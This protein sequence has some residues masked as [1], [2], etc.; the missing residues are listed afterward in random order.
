MSSSP[1]G[2][3]VTCNAPL[4]S[5]TSSDSGISDDSS[6]QPVPWEK[7][8]QGREQQSNVPP[9]SADRS[10]PPSGSKPLTPRQSHPPSLQLS[11]PLPPQ[12]SRQPWRQTPEQSQPPTP[13]P[14]QTSTPRQSQ[15][16]T[17][18]Q[19]QSSTPRETQPPK[20][21]QSQP[22]TPRQPSMNRSPCGTPLSTPRQ[23]QMPQ[24]SSKPIQ[25]R[26]GPSRQKPAGPAVP[27][28]ALPRRPSNPVVSTGP[29]GSTCGSTGK[30][31]QE[32]S[33]GPRCSPSCRPDESAID[34]GS[35]IPKYAP[36]PP[37]EKAA[38]C[39]I[40]FND[41]YSN[42]EELGALVNQGKRVEQSLYHGGCITMML[43]YR[44]AKVRASSNLVGGHQEISWGL[45]PVT[46][47]PVDSFVRMPKFEDA[48][49]WIEFVDWNR[50]GTVDV[51]KLGAAVAAL[52]PIDEDEAEPLVRKL[53]KVGSGDIISREELLETVLPHLQ[54]EAQS[55]TGDPGVE[56]TTYPNN[57]AV[58][59]GGP[60]H[61][62]RDSMKLL[63]KNCGELLRWRVLNRGWL[64]AINLS[65]AKSLCYEFQ[66]AGSGG[67]NSRMRGLTASSALARC[68]G[69]FA[70]GSGDVLCVATVEGLLDSGD[71]D[72]CKAAASALPILPVQQETV[73]NR[74]DPGLRRVIQA[75][76]SRIDSPTVFVRQ[77][78]VNILG[79]AALV[80]D[81]G[82]LT[83]LLPL[84]EDS[85]RE[86]V[87]AAERGLARI[88]RGD[89]QTFNAVMRR[90][91]KGSEA[92][93]N[94]A[95]EVLVSIVEVGDQRVINALIKKLTDPDIGM[96]CRAVCLLPRV[97]RQEDSTVLNAIAECVKSE[98][99]Y[100]LVYCGLKALTRLARPGD[101]TA[102]NACMVHIKSKN[103]ALRCQALDSLRIVAL[104]GDEMVFR[105]VLQLTRSED[106]DLIAHAAVGIGHLAT[107]QSQ[108][109]RGIAAI[110]EALSTDY[111]SPSTR[112]ASQRILEDLQEQHAL[113]SED[114]QGRASSGCFQLT[115][116]SSPRGPP[117]TG[118]SPSPRAPT[119]TT[120]S[121]TQ[122]SLSGW[123]SPRPRAEAS[124]SAP[125][126]FWTG[127]FSPRA[128]AE[129][130][131]SAAPT[132]FPGLF[133]PRPPAEASTSTS[134]TSWTGWFSPRAPAESSARHRV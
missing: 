98:A 65:L 50:Q 55:L 114:E 97:A 86:V 43:A 93:R 1:F 119:E 70:A 131:A 108:R 118:A 19:P 112:V 11:L 29:R 14:S 9:S 23:T 88:G 18:R 53:F 6:N 115:P 24:N 28:L 81:Q 42:R 4:P 13:R 111:T 71:E 27:K 48:D 8:T 75:A 117:E 79:T 87:K 130:S 20:P 57:I 46:R 92:S 30:P 72:V 127:L 133:S 67:Q 32:R 63:V 25:S 83:R 91:K 41:L 51:E 116:R 99:Q 58:K 15:P 109:R 17:P 21:R 22:P 113:A 62:L 95:L 124:T 44:G 125:Q 26:V 76:L 123:F 16:P 82:V 102:I 69:H 94:Q 36:P 105:T 129:S 60:T 120:T 52:L 132:F 89:D 101:K 68:V 103:S 107:T 134:Q 59:L 90:V 38:V 5:S 73:V 10:V 122:P 74:A 47:V 34:L 66:S 31:S 2:P 84:L 104:R 128:P 77:A 3:H 126:S 56:L 39:P 12:Q 121:A 110:K 45:S 35:S 40:C 100:N 78:A 33:F 49:R 106:K 80:G 37:P 64:K 61:P 54:K 96:R 7:A 85:D